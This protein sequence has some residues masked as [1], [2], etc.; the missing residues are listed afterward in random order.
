MCIYRYMY[1]VGE[2]C[3]IYG[4]CEMCTSIGFANLYGVLDGHYSDR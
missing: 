2:I 4:M 3:V 1:I